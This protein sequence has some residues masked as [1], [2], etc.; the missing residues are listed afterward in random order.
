MGFWRGPVN[1]VYM[2]RGEQGR[3]SSR[4]R[5][6]PR[7][8]AAAEPGPS[9]PH[10]RPAD[11][12][13]VGE[14][15]RTPLV[16]GDRRL[17]WALA[18]A[19]VPAAAVFPFA[20]CDWTVRGTLVLVTVEAALVSLILVWRDPLRFHWAGR[21]LLGLVAF[22][23]LA[24]ALGA[25]GPAVPWG[26]RALAFA[27]CLPFVVYTVTGSFERY[28]S[29][30]RVRFEQYGELVLEGGRLHFHE[31]WGK[32]GWELDVDQLVLVGEYTIEAWDDDYRLCFLRDASG[33]WLEA[34]FY[35]LGVSEA[36][37]HLG[38]Q[39]EAPLD[40]GLCNSTS[41]RS[42]VLWPPE[43]RGRPLLETQPRRAP[44]GPLEYGLELAGLR[45]DT[46]VV[47][48]YVLEHVGRNSTR[49]KR[50]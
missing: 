36:L 5:S 16:S 32:G 7:S 11:A 22:W 21:V 50:W 33:V 10:P 44:R 26:D 35:A 34:S 19:C 6:R 29:P 48:P 37:R 25:T 31:P 38:D 18:S 3:R 43:L 24:F 47:A 46:I 20:W 49:E 39:L 12:T 1:R 8:K 41:F 15:T 40:L 13:R 4:R 9:S 45:G 2:G 42:R 17:F 28:R 14:R 30:A 23:L 27:C